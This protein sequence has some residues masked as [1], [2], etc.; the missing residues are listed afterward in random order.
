MLLKQFS[1]LVIL[2]ALICLPL[3]ARQAQEPP[4]HVTLQGVVRTA[5]GVPIPGASVHIVEEN[6]GKSWVTW[7]DDQGKFRLPE[8]PGGKYRVEASQIGFG[9][10]TQELT[11]TSETSP[12]IILSLNVATASEIASANAATATAS[13]R[14]RHNRQCDS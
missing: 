14:K 4:A 12:D 9:T 13:C 5:G 3:A 8:L 2:L 11:P 7:T 1:R 10:G 6:S